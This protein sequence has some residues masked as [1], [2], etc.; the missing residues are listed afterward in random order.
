MC[1]EC[2]KEMDRV[3]VAI[4]QPMCND[5]LKA[6]EKEYNR[7]VFELLRAMSPEE[8]VEYFSRKQA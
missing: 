3:A 8:R 1:P 6:R 4:Q 5:C 2:G 7:R